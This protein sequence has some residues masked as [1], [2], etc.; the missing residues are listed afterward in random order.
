MRFTIESGRP[1]CATGV[2]GVAALVALAA[3]LAMPLPAEAARKAELSLNADALNILL[4]G[5]KSP[6]FVARGMAYEGLARGKRT[7][8]R[9]QALDDGKQDPQ[10][11]VRAGV[12]RAYVAQRKD[13]WKQLVS[14]ALTDPTLS[15]FE[16]LPVLDDLADKL[17]FGVLG[18]VL[19]DKEHERQSTIINAFVSRNTAQVGPFL[20]WCLSERDELMRTTCIGGVKKLSADLQL[21]HIA[22]V[23][24]KHAHTEPVIEALLGIA[25]S[26]EA[27]R[28]V[29]WL[30]DLKPKNA[31]LADRL[32]L[33]RARH[34][35]KGS[36]S[37]VLKIAAAA[38]G[39]ARITALI[40]YR[41][42]ARKEDAAA[43]KALLGK[44]PDGRLAFLI[45]E[46]L[47]LLGDRSM[48]SQA[49][50]LAEGTN[51]ELRPTGVYYLGRIGG[52][53]NLG[54]MH[55]YLRDGIPEV[56]IAAARVIGYLASPVS[57]A[58]LREG[59][60][61]EG[62]P[63]V[64]LELMRALAS[65][66]DKRAIQALMFYTRED[67][68]D[69]RLF[70]VKALA[71]SGE[72]IARP[73]LQAALNDQDARVRFEAVRGFILSDPAFAVRTWRRALGWMPP[74]SIIRLTRE[75]GKPMASYIELA[76]LSKRVEAREEALEAL[77]LLPDLEADLLEK[78]LAISDDDDLSVRV[79][80]R[81]VKLKGRDAGSILVPLATS[82]SVR[83]RIAA[84]RQLG[85]IPKDKEARAL[86]EKLLNEA[87]QRLRVAAAL[88]FLGG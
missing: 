21:G 16:V 50:G 56:R 27:S 37:A 24:R 83:V 49:R 65:I 48:A 86:L 6:D 81:M 12:A 63:R 45:Y 30:A 55:K 9:D 47:A 71:E 64:R 10:W 32:A 73:G 4:E 70:V 80:G 59:L 76:L 61:H 79:L 20:V 87:N 43:L 35:D 77:R 13:D 88:T 62:D 40:A 69:V 33:E 78:V 36:A 15:P 3:S 28:P 31:A 34:G 7:K 26:L 2:T 51:V 1:M 67:D 22:L 85:L 42:V 72:A 53:G 57:I 5:L 66:K 52:A 39:E 58:S 23:A 38:E 75:L 84:I 60:D 68:P 74:G 29:E 17:A 19:T 25:E 41:N 11:V 82:G 8:E 46:A 18:A 14:A 54:E 44:A